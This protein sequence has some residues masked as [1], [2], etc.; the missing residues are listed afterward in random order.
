MNTKP[1]S[2]YFQFPFCHK[3]AIF[4]ED[5]SNNMQH[6]GNSFVLFTIATKNGFF[7]FKLSISKLL[8]SKSDAWTW[9]LRC[10]ALYMPWVWEH[11]IKCMYLVYFTSRFNIY[12]SESTKKKLLF[13]DWCPGARILTESVARSR[14][15]PF[16]SQ[17]YLLYTLWLYEQWQTDA[18]II[19]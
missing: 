3:M 19:C 4:W 16:Y 18:N 1:Y 9:W 5:F 10:C 13:C 7:C 2:F 11:V 12:Y 8:S 17:W 15:L 14:H 6:F